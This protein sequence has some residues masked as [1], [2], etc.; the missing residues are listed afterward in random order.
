MD[1]NDLRVLEA[2]M[3]RPRDRENEIFSVIDWE[4][5][6]QV[7]KDNDIKNCSIGL[8][9]DWCWTADT[10]TKGGSIVYEDH[11]QL[12]SHWA[13]PHLQDD[14]TDIKYPVFSRLKASEFSEEDKNILPDEIRDRLNSMLGFDEV[15]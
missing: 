15:N 5:V 3:N 13:T 9:E 6:I 12:L 14:D 4:K 2:I 7:I 10:L 11:A 8:I 1:T